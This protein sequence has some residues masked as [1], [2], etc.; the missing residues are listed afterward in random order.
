[1]SRS[2]ANHNYSLRAYARDLGVSPGFLS[3]ILRGK[4]HLSQENAKSIFTTLG[5][6]DV[7]I[8]Y[9]EKLVFA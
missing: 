7:E 2:A 9:V 3:D 6:S 4:K 1:M 5:F 8:E